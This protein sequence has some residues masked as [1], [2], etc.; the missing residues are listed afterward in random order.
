MTATATPS[1]RESSARR[2]R[3]TK[4]HT[5]HIRMDEQLFALLEIRAHITQILSP[6]KP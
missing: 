5:A 4:T 3:Y 6:T 2:A 1:R